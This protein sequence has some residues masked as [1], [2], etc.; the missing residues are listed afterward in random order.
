[1]SKFG[2]A[3]D[4]GT[5][6]ISGALVDLDEKEIVLSLD[7]PNE[8][9]IYG[10]DVISRLK[11]ATKENGINELN[12]KLV[13]SIDSVIKTLISRAEVTPSRITRILAVGNAAMYHLIFLLPV[14]TLARAPF[15]PF[16]TQLV[17]KKA[18]DVGLR[19]LK[20]CEFVFLPT[21][22]G[23][24]GSDTIG[25]IS[26]LDMHKQEGLKLAVD[27]GT[28]GEV[29]L[30]NRKKIL[31][32]STAAGPAFEGWHI[33]C[34]MR[35][36]PGAIVYFEMKN[37][38]TTLKTIKDLP[39]R[40]I[41]SSGLIKIVNTLIEGSYIDGTGRLTG[42]EFSIYKDDE[43]K[44]CVNQKDIR[45]IQL[46]KSAIQTAITFLMINYGIGHDDIGEV[47]ITGKFGG[48][49]NKEDLIKIGI[50]PYELKEKSFTFME[51]LALKGACLFLTEDRMN[52]I[53]AVLKIARHIELHKERTFQE[54]FAKGMHFT[55]RD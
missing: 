1:M 5:T 31:V 37:G 26:A 22:G 42:E 41:A 17:R 23:F 10:D 52:E 19:D 18:K 13:T 30:G 4:I 49:L 8:Q 36:V 33:S 47:I 53:D 14:N 12:K 15:S 21:I 24:V 6:N 40:G 2:I 27:L 3:L 51:N 35:P 45:E 54:E 7:R 39:P 46:A 16:E 32:T 44:I 55:R 34:G 20:G 25:V 38:K 50:V 48:S 43:R 28:N 29:I 9:A 11:F